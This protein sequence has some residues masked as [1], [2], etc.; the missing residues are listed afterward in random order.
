LLRDASPIFAINAQSV[1]TLII[2]GSID[3][4]VPPSQSKTLQTK[5][6]SFNVPVSYIS[7]P[8]GHGLDGL[9]NKQIQALTLQALS[10]LTAHE[11]P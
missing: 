10:F 5:L 9:S 7:Y 3:T 11:L 8:G 2:Q 4:V 6:Q 1:P